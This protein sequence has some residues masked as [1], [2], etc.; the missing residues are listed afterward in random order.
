MPPQLVTSGSGKVTPP[1]AII[2]RNSHSVRKFSPVATGTPPSRTTR[3][4]PATSSGMIGSSSQP[5]VVGRERPRGADRL[6]GGP[7][8]VG[9][10]HQ[11]KVGAEEV[12]HRRDPLDILREAL[13]TDLHLDRAEALGEVVLGLPQ[14]PVERIVEVDAAGIA[15][16]AADRCRRAA[17]TAAG[18]AAPPSGPRA[19]C[20]A[21]T[22]PAPSARRGRRSAS[23]T[24][25]SATGARS[26]RHPRR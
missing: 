11:R 25:P 21:P 14:Q 24:R 12:A 15:G 18:R 7:L 23:P 13:A 1:A 2:C 10:D 5:M 4:W 17:A 20:R 22:A 26:G 9:V 3:T 8:H 19:P 6:V 16:D